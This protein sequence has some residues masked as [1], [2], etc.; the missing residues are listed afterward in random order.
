MRAAIIG[1]GRRGREHAT[2][3][4]SVDGIELVARVDTDRA[5]APH[6]AIAEVPGAAELDVVVIATPAADRAK[7][8]AEVLADTGARAVICE[9]PLALDLAEAAWVVDACAAAGVLLAVSLQSRFAESFRILHRAVAEGTVGQVERLSGACFGN[10]L[11]QGI[12][13]IDAMRWVA[14]ADVEWVMSSAE[15]EPSVLSELAPAHVGWAHDPAHPAPAWMTHHL[16]LGNGIRAELETGLLVQRTV[17][18]VDDWLQRRLVVV[19]TDG[20]AEAWVTGRARVVSFASGVVT[21]RLPAPGDV[22]AATV[23]LHRNVVAALRGRE[24]LEATGADALASLE[25]ALA[26]LQSASSGSL[27]TLPLDQSP[28]RAA[29][30]INASR[31]RAI[32]PLVSVVI[33]VDDDRQFGP[34]AIAS[35]R[36]DQGYDGPLELVLVSDG[37]E[38]DLDR[39]LR[40]L[41][42]AT[43]RHV[44]APGASRIELYDAGARS[45]SGDIVVIT[46]AHCAAEP[47]C[48]GALVRALE[49][50]RVHA[51]AGG[52]VAVA[53]SRFGRLDAEIFERGTDVY[54]DRSDW[55]KVAPHALAIRRRS[56]LQVGGFD[57]RYDLY[58][59]QLLAAELRRAGMPIV[60]VDEARVRHRFADHPDE[61][62]RVME[63]F[64]RGQA[65]ARAE[66]APDEFDR[67]LFP[68]G[69]LDAV[70]VDRTFAVRA[71]AGAVSAGA[72]RPIAGRWLGPALLPRRLLTGADGVRLRAAVLRARFCRSAE[73]LEQ[74]YL[75]MDTYA[76]RRARRAVLQSAGPP[77]L[78]GVD[79][80]GVWAASDLDDGSWSGVHEP[81][82]WHGQRFVW[83]EPVAALRTDLPVGD[84]TFVLHT[85]GF[86][87]DPRTA[88]LRV[89]LDGRRL[90]AKGMSITE[91][92]VT[93]ALPRRRLRA[94]R[95]QCWVLVTDPLTG[96]DDDRRLGLPIT[97]LEL[98]PA[99]PGVS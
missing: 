24:H 67:V 68:L 36:H 78:S 93:I 59:Q 10:V 71:M 50:E 44:V 57:V 35:W 74:A 3:I 53:D 1:A 76:T 80:S 82:V 60:Q 26:C 64:A 84:W 98:R 9:K 39:E 77:V 54:G 31:R 7:A 65:L 45:A 69:G 27:I 21:E 30:P 81:E 41:L 18:G 12:H 19:G 52:V 20:M 75:D 97:A 99:A 55:R 40:D 51:A 56:F 6:G 11:D 95:S 86:G 14:G 15:D 49:D 23:G 47:G 85:G 2:A 88:G 90:P 66:R 79:A 32:P 38:P 96:A 73:R 70:E 83:T 25:V 89:R 94:G 8:V 42:D 5:R 29:I 4:D 87:R 63:G 46:E 91:S 48:L 37:S 28:S 92:S 72:T 13:L 61:V 58:A 16:G 33:N 22:H 17:P 34:E 62:L 43:D